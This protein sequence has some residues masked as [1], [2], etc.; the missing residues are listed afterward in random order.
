MAHVYVGLGSNIEPETNLRLGLR[1]LRCRYGRLALS[2]VYRSAALGFEGADFLNMVAG[3]HTDAEPAAIHAEIET[4]HGVAGRSRGGD[5]FLSRPLDIDLLLYDDRV[6][7]EPPVRLPRADVLEYA[8][9]LRPLSELDPHG[10]HPVTQKTF[11]EHWQAFDRDA[12]PMTRVD[13]VLDVIV[14]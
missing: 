5:R 10:R 9:V 2:A 4:I 1:E 12:H 8:F 7:N 11:A 13:D 14:R 3:F 6:C